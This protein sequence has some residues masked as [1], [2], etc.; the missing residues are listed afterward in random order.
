MRVTM[1]SRDTLF[2]ICDIDTD[3]QANYAASQL[4]LSSKSR[5]AHY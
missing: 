3:L 2:L 4:S 1:I 5:N